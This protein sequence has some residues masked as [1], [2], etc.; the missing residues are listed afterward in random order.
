MT[1]HDTPEAAELAAL[2]AALA[3]DAP[4]AEWA[5]LV[6]AVREDAPP[7]RSRSVQQLDARVA[8]GFPRERPRWLPSFQLGLGRSIAAFACVVLLAGIVGMSAITS[9]GDEEATTAAS[10]VS[11][12]QGEAP[13]ADSAASAAPSSSAGGSTASEAAAPRRSSAPPAPVPPGATPPAGLE[14]RARKVERDAQLTLRTPARGL[15]DAADGIVRVTQDLGGVVETSTVDSSA[16]GGDASFVLRIPT[17][18]LP[19]ALKRFGEL[20]DVRRLTQGAQDVTGAF[21]SVQDRLGDARAE[22]KALLKALGRA[23]TQARIASLRGRIAANRTEI[24]R[25]EGDVRS[26]RR[27]TDTARVDVQLTASGTEATTPRDDGEGGAWGPRDAARDALRV[28]AVIAGVALIALAVLLPLA[29]L[30][31]GAALGGRGLRRR[32]R[33]AALG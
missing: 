18:Q 23:T 5:A 29:L 22:R 17:A 24:A 31:G 21:V 33:E 13:S 19:A 16:A 10:S 15:Q 11:T 6:R 32:R 30:G 12:T 28:L 20:G 3:G 2:E 4:D 25:L 1:R 7:P 27:R 14:R 8:A 9:G 26:L